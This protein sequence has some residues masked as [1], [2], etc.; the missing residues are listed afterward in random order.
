MPSRAATWL[1]HELNMMALLFIVDK[2]PPTLCIDGFM[3][4]AAVQQ[5]SFDQG[6]FPCFDFDAPFLATR[7]LLHNCCRR[8]NMTISNNFVLKGDR[9]QTSR[10]L[11]YCKLRRNLDFPLYIEQ[12]PKIANEN[13][14]DWNRAMKVILILDCTGRMAIH[15]LKFTI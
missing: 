2:L 6:I 14:I 15:T 10:K 1:R 5:T 13:I 3:N 11:S 9:D 7:Y 4:Y 12:I 8:R